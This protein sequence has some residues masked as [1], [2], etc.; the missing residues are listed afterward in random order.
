MLADIS[1][2]QGLQRGAHMQSSRCL[3]KMGSMSMVMAIS[4]AG[5]QSASRPAENR[6][7]WH[8]TPQQAGL[9]CEAVK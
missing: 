6:H 8:T 5:T 2:P 3:K 1:I 4:A 7:S 9:T